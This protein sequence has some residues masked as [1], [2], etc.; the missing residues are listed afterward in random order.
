MTKKSGKLLKIL[1]VAGVVLIIA[2]YFALRFILGRNSSLRTETAT[3][4][5]VSDT[6][7]LEAW[8]I[9][10]ESLVSQT[11][12]GVLAYQLDDGDRVSSGG[13]IANIYL[14]ESDASAQT[15]AAKIDS[16]INNIKSLE[17][18]ENLLS[19]NIDA[20]GSRIT[21]TLASTKEYIWTSDYNEAADKKSSLQYLLCE[22]QIVLGNESSDAITSRI[23]AL[24][25]EKNLLLST[26]SAEIGKV[27]AS[28][29]GYFSSNVDGYESLY[30]TDDIEN[31]TVSDIDSFSEYRAAKGNFCGKVCTSFTW[32]VVAVVDES[33]KIKLEDSYD[34]SVKFQSSGGR[35]ISA[36]LVALNQDPETGNYACVLACS[37]MS[38]DL[39]NLRNEAVTVILEDYSGVLVSEKAVHF[40]N[41][42]ETVYDDNGNASEVVH[43]NVRGVYVKSGERLKFVQIFTE[44]TINGYCICRTTLTEK[45]KEELVT[46]STIKLYDEVV[47]GGTNLYDGK[48]IS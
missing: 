41:V 26:S 4:A 2:L 46:S 42:T 45:D 24:E 12:G 20:I 18:A 35:E 7:E 48:I 25:A 32:Y 15:Q 17:T 1:L 6:L 44:R 16:E 9:R 29:A 34:L 38:D 10:D 27:T 5:K 39:I 11:T 8:V 30:S 43:E 23:N 28:E 21:E 37:Y 36:E 40:A 47:V 3:Y 31:I 19:G 14:S 13:T 33:Q 22:K